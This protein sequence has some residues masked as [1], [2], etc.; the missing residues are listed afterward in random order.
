MNNQ[1]LFKLLFKEK[2]MMRRMLASILCLSFLAL[3]S[4]TRGRGGEGERANSPGKSENNCFVLSDE[5]NALLLS[6]PKGKGAWRIEI[7]RSG[8]MRPVK[9]TVQLNSTGEINV[10]SEQM[11]GGKTTVT[12]SRKEK[13]S[14]RELLKINAA[15]TS[16]KPSA[17]KDSYSDPSHP[18]C[19]DQP[20]TEVKLQRRGDKD[21]EETS[22]SWYPGS[23]NLVPTDLKAIATFIQP[24]WDAVRDHCD[25]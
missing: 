3:S 25:K 20:T 5:G 9:E 10:L 24:Q 6:L 19:C 12:C 8:G 21:Q 1:G 15:I 13:L 17:W 14:P 22:T 23:Y 18:I 11:S 4:T 7:G 2:P 16:A